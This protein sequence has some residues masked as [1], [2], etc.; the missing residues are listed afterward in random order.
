MLVP[1]PI[2]VWMLVT[3][4]PIRSLLFGTELVKRTIPPVPPLLHPAAV[5]AVFALV[6]SMVFFAV[7]VVV[8]FLISLPFVLIRER[9]FMG[10]TSILLEIS[11]SDPQR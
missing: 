11:G 6:P 2:T 1:V 9:N 10:L 8:P 5:R 4:L 3:P 7:S